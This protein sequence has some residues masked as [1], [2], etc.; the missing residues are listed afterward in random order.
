MPTTYPDKRKAIAGMFFLIDSRNRRRCRKAY[1]KIQTWKQ[2]VPVEGNEAYTQQVE[3]MVRSS[4]F[5]EVTNVF[6]LLEE[7]FYEKH[8]DN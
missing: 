8:H 5:Q 4:F 6:V 1:K 2:A 7:R 3:N